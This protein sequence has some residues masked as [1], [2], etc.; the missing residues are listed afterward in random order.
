MIG[1]TDVVTCF[2]FTVSASAYINF[3]YASSENL[4]GERE[5]RDYNNRRLIS[6]QLFGFADIPLSEYLYA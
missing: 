3:S 1:I 5:Y 4:K 6:S 2:S